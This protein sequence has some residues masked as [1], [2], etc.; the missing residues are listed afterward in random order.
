[1]EGDSLPCKYQYDVTCSLKPPT[2]IPT[3]CLAACKT[4]A[5]SSTVQVHQTE[6]D[7]G[8]SL[9]AQLNHALLNTFWG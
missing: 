6:P 7:G 3:A 4:A 1:M 9:P 5:T 8:N 2:P